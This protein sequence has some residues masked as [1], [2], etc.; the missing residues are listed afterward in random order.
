M[1][2]QSK[3]STKPFPNHTFFRSLSVL[4]FLCTEPKKGHSEVLHSVARLSV[5]GTVLCL[6]WRNGW[7][8]KHSRPTVVSTYTLFDFVTQCKIS[9]VRRGLY[10]VNSAAERERGCCFAERLRAL[11]SQARLCYLGATPAQTGLFLLQAVFNRLYITVP[12]TEPFTPDLKLNIRC[13]GM[14]HF[15]I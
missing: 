13:L 6:D 15:L 9:E 10:G 7:S 11:E 2:S 5:D 8:L 12:F 3:Q 4:Y 1:N 14:R